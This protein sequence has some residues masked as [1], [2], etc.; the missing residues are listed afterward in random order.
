MKDDGKKLHVRRMYDRYILLQLT[1]E[2]VERTRQR[3]LILE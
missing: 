2:G 1:L 3:Y